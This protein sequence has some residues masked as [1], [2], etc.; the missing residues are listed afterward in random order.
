MTIDPL[1]P[2]GPGGAPTT[3][4]PTNAFAF[5]PPDYNGFAL[6]TGYGYGSWYDQ[7]KDAFSMPGRGAGVFM[8]NQAPRYGTPAPNLTMPGGFQGLLAQAAQQYPAPGMGQPQQQAPTAPP[9]ASA[10][11]SGGVYQPGAP[12]PGSAAGAPQGLLGPNNF[13]GG[14]AP[15]AN[16]ANLARSL[17]PR[18]SAGLLAAMG[19]D[20]SAANRMNNSYGVGGQNYNPQAI[21]DQTR[22]AAGGIDTLMPGIRSQY[23]AAGVIKDGKWAKKQDDAGNWVSL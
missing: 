1:N 19:G 22:G 17:D 6:N 10:A 13:G 12:Q 23:E 8:G 5:K 18:D 3:A 7:L 2:T 21:A 16:A 15:N 4:Q 14:N 20:Q 9:M 11:P